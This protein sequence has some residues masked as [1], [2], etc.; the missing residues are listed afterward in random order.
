M[1]SLQSTKFAASAGNAPA[2]VSLAIAAIVAVAL[3]VWMA[4]LVLS[5]KGAWMKKE[6][7]L[8]GMTFAALRAAIIVMLVGYYVN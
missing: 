1:T 6:I 7:S 3:L 5:T 2:D 8:G 4:W